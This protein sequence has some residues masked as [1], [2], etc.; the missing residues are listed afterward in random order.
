MASRSLENRQPFERLQLLI[1][2]KALLRLCETRIAVFGVGGVGSWC[3]ESLV[4][5]G[6][7]RLTIV[8]SDIICPTNINRQVQ[9]TWSAIGKPKVEE[10]RARLLAINPHVNVDTRRELYC[11]DTAPSFDLKAFDYVIDAIDTLSSKVE[12]LNNALCAGVTVFSSFGAASK[13][14]PTRIRVDSIWKTEGCPLGKFVRKRLR[15]RMRLSGLEG[16]LLCV[17]SREQSGGSEPLEESETGHKQL[18]GTAVHVTG[19]FGFTLTGLVIQ[20]V[21]RRTAA[22]KDAR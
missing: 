22:E 8:D 9:A 12:L 20:D 18:N 19:A 2:E 4:R 14:D 11:A 13:L 17:Y 3:A 15:K 5:S 6:V 7:G 16:D 1:G 10:L 21:V